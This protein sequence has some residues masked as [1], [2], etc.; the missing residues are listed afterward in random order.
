MNAAA[1]RLLQTELEAL[2]LYRDRID[3]DRGPNTR[4]AV[5]ATLD[6]RAG[7]LPGGWRAWSDKRK[8]VALL[9]LLCGDEA[10]DPGM[11]DGWWGPQTEF[12]FEQLEA[13]RRTG[14]LPPSWRD[15]EPLDANPHGFPDESHASLVAFYGPNGERGGYRPPLCKV[16]CPWKL[17]I[18]WNMRQTRSHLWCHEGA[19]DSLAE[20]LEKVHEHYGEHEIGKLGLDLFGGD[21]HPR[22]K[23]GGV[24]WSTHSWG[25]AIDWDPAC[26]RLNWGH[27]RARLAEPDY[28]D[29]WRIWEEQGWTSLGRARNFDWMHVQAA[30]L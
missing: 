6:A 17:K 2:G 29:W 1:V 28:E 25:I 26:N 10:I 5:V 13:K 4:A 20:V 27:G 30:K 18:A 8:A 11:V 19:A 22:K 15:V 7:D 12:A 9:Q 24:T 16:A 14:V 21:Y 23:R 3:G